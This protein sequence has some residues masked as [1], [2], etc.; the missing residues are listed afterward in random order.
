MYD[1]VARNATTFSHRPLCDKRARLRSMGEAPVRKR[2]KG[3][4]ERTDLTV[5]QV[6]DVVG[7]PKSTYAS[8]EDKYD[9]E[10]LPVR[11]VLKLIPLFKKRG[12]AEKELWLLTDFPL[13]K[14]RLYSDPDEDRAVEMTRKLAPSQRPAWF[15]V[16]DLLSQRT[17][18]H[19]PS[20][21]GPERRTGTDRRQH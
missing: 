4:R 2:L 11:L 13:E 5:Q 10:F 8:Y 1:A 14:L 17:E 9:K 20:N 18:P 3:L 6:A 16:G 7:M 15:Q 21:A 12:V 19:P